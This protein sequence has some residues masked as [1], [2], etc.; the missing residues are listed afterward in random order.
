MQTGDN[1]GM[2]RH[3]LVG[4]TIIPLEATGFGGFF[5]ADI[6]PQQGQPSE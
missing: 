3:S 1:T 2:T 4:H 5:T 6:T